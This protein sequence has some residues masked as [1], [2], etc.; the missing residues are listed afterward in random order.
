MTSL[1]TVL[2]PQWKADVKAKSLNVLDAFTKYPTLD[3]LVNGVH[4]VITFAPKNFTEGDVWEQLPS[5]IRFYYEALGESKI[6]PC[7]ATRRPTSTG[8]E[9]SFIAGYSLM[10]FS[11]APNKSDEKYHCHCFIYGIHNH[12]GTWSGWQKKFDR[13][14]RTLKC[15]SSTGH[16]VYYEPV[17]DQVDAEMRENYSNDY[18]QPLVDYINDRKEPSLMNYFSSKNN[19]NFVYHYLA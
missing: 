5:I 18:Y 17:K 13:S 15:I 2:A 7:V 14:M 9:L 16:P 12:Q 6:K 3:S 4:I 8:L 19:K 10:V 1:V 11:I